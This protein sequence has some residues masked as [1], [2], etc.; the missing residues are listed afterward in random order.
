M[1]KTLSDPQFIT[2][3]EFRKVGAELAPLFTWRGLDVYPLFGAE[4]DDDADV[5]S[6]GA[7]DD[8]NDDDTGD[9]PEVDG[10]GTVSRSD[11]EKLQNQLRAADKGRAALEQKLKEIDDAKKDELTKATERAEELEK[12]LA[13]RDTE[14]A[15]MRLQNAFLTANTGITWKDPEDALD[16]AERR[17]YLEGVVS[18][19]GK[20]DSGKL[21]SKLKELAKAKPHLVES[22]GSNKEEEK[23]PTGQSV[24]SKGSN[25]KQ[26]GGDKIPARY[27]RFLNR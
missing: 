17:G 1:T 18:E 26:Q 22:D 27:G 12:A 24:G 20:V 4:G 10:T 11:F 9:K 15:N 25:G 2:A 3:D 5:D 14:L 8:D 7:P 23:K 6:D 19:D 21:A 13:D 16:L